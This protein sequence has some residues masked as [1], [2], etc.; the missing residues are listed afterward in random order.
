MKFT[1]KLF[2]EVKVILL[3]FQRSFT[4]LTFRERKLFFFV[5]ISNALL[6]FLDLL[7]LAL[8]T[9]LISI[10]S[11]TSYSNQSLERIVKFFSSG[12]MNEKSS[13]SGIFLITI[14]MLL[15]I[16]I[17]NLFSLITMKRTLHLL[18]TASKRLG[19]EI[20]RKIFSSDYILRRNGKEKEIQVALNNGVSAMSIEILSSLQVLISEIFLIIV[21]SGFMFFVNPKTA[22]L[23][24]LF[25]GIT[26]LLFIHYLSKK[27]FKA[28]HDRSKSIENVTALVK[29]SVSGLKELKIH[30]SE[31]MQADILKS[32]E[33]GISGVNQS[34]WVGYLPKILLEPIVVAGLLMVMGFYYLNGMPEVGLAQGAFFLMMGARILPSLLRIQSALTLTS[35]SKAAAD[36]A[37]RIMDIAEITGD[38]EKPDSQQGNSKTHAN[39]TFTILGEKIKFKYEIDSRFA[40]EVENFEINRGE[41]IAVVG[42]SGSGKTTFIDMILG[43]NR[44][45]EGSLSVGGQDFYEYIHD[46]K[47]KIGY[48]PQENIIYEGSFARNVLNTY[49][50]DGSEDDRILRVSEVTQLIS[51]LSGKQDGINTLI[52]ENGRNLSGGQRQ[53]IAIARALIRNPDLLVL[54]EAT[55]ALDEKTES[56]FLLALTET[57]PKLTVIMV[58]HRSTA[59]KYATQIFSLENGMLV[60]NQ[61]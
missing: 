13:L 34:I 4:I 12:T 6:A 29:E 47:I 10:I 58:T 39:Q 35:I 46:Q 18:S 54:D 41:C 27:A 56:D 45:N 32:R 28:G 55:S 19:I 5:S 3:T 24:F 38:Y 37:F 9:I 60:V 43:L 51:F 30:G 11:G 59:L 2:S 26:N 57:F 36:Y 49:V 33:I 31:R 61:L 8:L 15:L 20:T 25:F 21:L 48:V 1:K 40:L 42:Q 50:P 16:L 22:L 17:K 52:E 23:T 53:R 44:P 14:G 7:S